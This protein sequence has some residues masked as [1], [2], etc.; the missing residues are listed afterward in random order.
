MAKH[1][2]EGGYNP[3]DEIK[4][5]ILKRDIPGA[6]FVEIER[7]IVEEQVRKTFTAESIQELA[8]SIKEHGLIN[9][10]TVKKKGADFLL[11]SGERRLKALTLLGEKNIQIIERDIKDE[12]I[13]FV[14]II[15][16]AQRE[17]L[18]P[19]ELAESYK[20]LQ[21]EY[22][23]SGR[24]I[25]KKVGKTEAHIRQT[26][27]LLNLPDNLKEGVRNGFAPSKAREI[28]K[29][30]KKTQKEVLKN[31]EK[32]SRDDIR[33][34]KNKD[35]EKESKS[36]E[37]DTGNNSP[38]LNLT[39]V[40]SEDQKPAPDFPWVKQGGDAE[41]QGPET[42]KGS[43]TG[44]SYPLGIPSGYPF[45]ETT[46]AVIDD[47][48]NN[49]VESEE[50]RQNTEDVE[51]VDE[52]TDNTELEEEN[53]NVQNVKP[54]TES[55]EKHENKDDELGDNPCRCQN[56]KASCDKVIS[57]E[58]KGKI[59]SKFAKFN[60]THETIKIHPFFNADSEEFIE[61]VKAE[62]YFDNCFTADTFINYLK[63]FSLLNV[64]KK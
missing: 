58:I 17:D 62:I 14:Q 18:S 34:L 24:E 8:E 5:K 36:K 9:P 22:K 21:E 12:D 44:H 6:R 27:E 54:N 55:Q 51:G 46:K 43:E 3:L 31:P 50:Q 57:D 56:G 10:L 39:A 45:G 32:Y 2:F 25:A 26:L 53:K 64:Y 41:E 4:D 7:I 48:Y 42:K 28:S 20:K 59:I 11:I 49:A 52:E 19:L 29:L 63:N 33:N 61:S 38:D 47:F 35:T 30:D 60:L 37:P 13:A 40:E 15:E 16:N 23:L 1:K